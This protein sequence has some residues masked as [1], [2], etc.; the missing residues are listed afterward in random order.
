MIISK[1]ICTTS[2][3]YFV[4]KN[5]INKVYDTVKEGYELLKQNKDNSV[6]Y[7]IDRYWHKISKDNKMFIFKNKI[8]FQKPAV[9]K[10]LNKHNLN[11]D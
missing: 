1:Q 6:I 5:N 2:S 4:S 11:L 7:C 9:S 10:I 3:A 8:G